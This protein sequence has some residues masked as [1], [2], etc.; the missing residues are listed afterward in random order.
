MRIIIQHL[1]IYLLILLSAFANITRAQQFHTPKQ[2][3]EYFNQGNYI[4]AL[5]IYRILLEKDTTNSE[6]NHKIGICYL[7]TN[8][9]NAKAI[10][11]LERAIKQPKYDKVA[12]YDLAMAY[13]YNYRFYDARQMYKEFKAITKGKN[14]YNVDRQIETCFVAMEMVRHPLNVRFENLGPEINSEYPDYYPFVA[15][16]ESFIVFTSR[17]SGIMEFD[18]FYSSDIWI[19]NSVNGKFTKATNA[20]TLVNSDFDEQAVG[21]SDDG[22]IVFVY[23]DHIDEYGDIY[24]SNRNRKVFEKTVKMGE[25]IN[26][27]YFEA[28]ASLSA[29][30]NT[31]F[32]SSFRSGGYGGLDLYM[33]RKLPNGEWALPQNLGQKI[34]TQ[35][36]E[37]FPTLSADGNNLYFCSDG[38]VG[39]GGYDLF[40]STWD[41]EINTWTYPK[42]MR[43]PINTPED[44]MTIS[45][46]E[47]NKHAYVSAFRKDGVGDLDIYKVT[48]YD[49]KTKFAIL[50]LQ[51]P[52]GDTINP[53]IIDTTVTVTKINKDKP[54]G[55][56]RPNH[57]SG[58]YTII[59]QP[60]N[61]NMMI[62]V[63]GHKPYDEQFNVTVISAYPPVIFKT[64]K[65]VPD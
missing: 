29:D 27:D 11:Y 64:I 14:S 48:F 7:R 56:Y 1:Y 38:H 53:Y 12:L 62:N 25:Q 16:D 23:T 52:T 22:K 63:D 8:I 2:A 4:T 61:Y 17:R 5:E 3:K 33:T 30:T 42:N 60:G 49:T 18:G 13:Q 32:F 35:Y 54:V 20:G 28:S 44:D 10:P 46:T 41:T 40:T 37:D 15:K 6:Y 43:Y 26:S 39:M 58:F 34:N 65:L 45:F 36:N 19:S 55:I 31:L 9:D 24:T 21:L 59:L 51:I 57:N 50:R 47:D